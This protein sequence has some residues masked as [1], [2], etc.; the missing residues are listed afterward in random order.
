M[1]ARVDGRDC[2]LFSVRELADKSLTLI[3]NQPGSYED[4]VVSPARPVLSDKI[5]VHN[6]E[7]QRYNTIKNEMV[8]ED[9]STYD[10]H[11]QTDAFNR[12]LLVPIFAELSPDLRSRSYD[13]PKRGKDQAVQIGQPYNP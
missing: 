13:Y 8:F 6:T 5:S 7:G 9:G 12:G 10:R 2:L 1:V 11:I 4:A 3:L